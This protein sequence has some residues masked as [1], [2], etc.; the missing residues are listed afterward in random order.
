MNILHL[1]DI[2]FGRNNY[3]IAEPF[4]NKQEI[5][6]QLIAYITSLNDELKPDLV[7]TT[8]DVA[9]HG[10]K[11]EFDEAYSWYQKLKSALNIGDDCFVFCAG[12]HDL[13]R[14]TAIDF[15]EQALLANNHQIDVAKCDKYYQYEN[16][17]ILEPRFHNYNVFCEKMGMQPYSYKLRNG[18]L[19]YSYLIGSS[20]F[21]Y[22]TEVY[23]ISS[24]NTAYLPIGKVLRDD[25]MFLGLPQIQSQISRGILSTNPDNIYRIA[26]FH[27][28]DRFL[29]PNEQSE[30]NDRPAALPLLLSTVNL[31]LC[32][33][34]ETGGVPVLRSYSHGGSLLTAGAAYYND[35][36]PNS[37]SIIH[38]ENNDAPQVFSFYYD[39]DE[40]CPFVSNPNISFSSEHY[41]IAWQ[42]SIH[43]REHMGF[44]AYIDGALK[45]IYSG[46]F[47]VETIVT[48]AGEQKA[49]T[50]TLNPARGIDVGSEPQSGKLVADLKLKHAPA[51]FQTTASLLMLSMFQQFI[52][53]NI[54]NARV[55]YS[56][57]Y[58][59]NNMELLYCIPMDI[60]AMQQK[61]IGRKPTNELYEKLQDLEHFYGIQFRLPYP[62]SLSEEDCNIIDWL[63]TIQQYGHLALSIPDIKESF[64]CVH[65]EAEINWI[66]NV[67]TV[68]G[69]LSYHFTRNLA[70][71]LYGAT[72]QLGKCHIYCT[73]AKLK[74]AEE[75]N[76]KI[77][78]WEKGDVR[79]IATDFKD[80]ED[81]L[82]ISEKYASG[83]NIDKPQNVYFVEFPEQAPLL[84]ND[85]LKKH[86]TEYPDPTSSH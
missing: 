54:A 44:G 67:C 80:G 49:L 86:I 30:Y 7:I 40:W 2:H 45:I 70:I 31:A 10:L 43:K 69:T 57:W 65:N 79:Q 41:H 1:S 47:D 46:Y 5:L 12:N 75:I 42:D 55:A 11:T 56:G 64:F 50:N 19:E 59:L 25:Q 68:N 83:K 29:H 51:Q 71:S 21:N 52:S 23:S 58:N 38:L 76:R 6:E 85:F 9:W 61:Y 84:F 15:S 63:F 37:F 16:A 62:F 66:K 73:G 72:I 24:F 32:G 48:D 8:G 36:H 28:A 33:H 81:I 13:N 60:K 82:I 22:G 26:L 17:H 53:E 74:S 14:N 77:S 34:T 20:Q 4:D 18:K 35:E 3:N 39:K 27:H 78:T